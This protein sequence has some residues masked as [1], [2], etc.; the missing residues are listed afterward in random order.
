[1]KI[2]RPFVALALLAGVA[3][4]QPPA[5]SADEMRPADVTK[6]LAFFDRLVDAVVK[7]ED[8]CDKMAKDVAYVID[9]GQDSIALARSA[10]T[11]HKKLPEA[12][13]QHMIDGVKKM[14][15]GIDKC[16]DNERV[17]AAFAKLE[18]PKEHASTAEK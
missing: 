11:Q 3:S 1:M 15:P 5:A 6:W 13:Q 17:K 7:N 14:S 12:A 9:S 16:G 18:P 8:A 10:R 4:A 2:L